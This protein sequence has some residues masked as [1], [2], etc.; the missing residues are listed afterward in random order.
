M[1]DPLTLVPCL[2][3]LLAS[4]Q[5]MHQHTT[6]AFGTCLGGIIL[7]CDA[8]D[9]VLWSNGAV[10]L[11]PWGLPAGSYTYTAYA[12]GNVIG[13]GTQEVEQ[14]QW[15]IM[16]VLSYPMAGAHSISAWAQLPYCGTSAFNSPCCMPEPTSTTMRLVQDGTTEITTPCSNCDAIAC[17]GST[18]VF[19]N[20]P[21]GHTYQ[22]R[23][24]DGSC[25]NVLTDTTVIDIP[26]ATGIADGPV[27]NDPTIATDAGTL[28]VRL[29][30]SAVAGLRFFDG[31][32]RPVSLPQGAPGT[33]DLEGLAAGI[34]LV[35]V[36]VGKEVRTYRFVHR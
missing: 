21:P 26:L 5:C 10:G 3:P 16:N 14:L 33:F 8:A 34:Y 12:D 23:L 36:P 19:N 20:V 2:L 30:G 18:V 25:G 32:G 6:H 22:L 24:Y 7:T 11:T 1:R 4:A 9:S 31:L 17:F 28:T 15:A 27:N 29:N 13:T 35:S